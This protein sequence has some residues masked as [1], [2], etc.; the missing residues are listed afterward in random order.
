MALHG[1]YTVFTKSP[2]RNF[3]GTSTAHASGVGSA[4][5]TVPSNWGRGGAL[6]NWAFQDGDDV[7]EHMCIPEGYVAEGWLLPI[8]EGSI[9]SHE[10]ILCEAE[11]TASGARGVNG[12]VAIACSGSLTATGALVV[13]GSATIACSASVSANVLAAL[14]GSATLTGAASL[15]GTSVAK[16][17]MSTAISCVASLTGTRYGIGYMSA[18]IQ[19]PTQLEAAEFSTYVLDQEDVETGLTVRNAL[20]LMAAAMAG[21]IS[22][23]GTTTITIRNA[24]A[25]DKDRIVATVTSEGNRTALTYDL[26]DS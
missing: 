16:G 12:S 1:N 19:P 18:N 10:Q 26:T 17:F 15:T 20:R 23:A 2:C 14:L 9:S 21:E 22:G 5:V 7:L 11:L 3:G 13:S 24:V 4:Q 6:R 25:D 8:T